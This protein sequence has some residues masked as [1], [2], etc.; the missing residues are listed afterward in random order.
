[1]KRVKFKMGDVIVFAPENFRGNHWENLSE[2]DR[3]K[4]YGALGYGAKKKK[5]FVY[6]TAIY[7][8]SDPEFGRFNSGHC[9]LVDMDD[10]HLEVMRHPE[11]FRLATGEE[12]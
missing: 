5:L 6:L 10:G 11:D 3:I 8:N 4:Y 7:D 12:F 9:V 2:E 1:M